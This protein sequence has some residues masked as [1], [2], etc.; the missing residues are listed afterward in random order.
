MDNG[1][2][3]VSA[4]LKKNG[5]NLAN[6]RRDFYEIS[7]ITYIEAYTIE[8]ILSLNANDYIQLYMSAD[9]GTNSLQYTGTGTTPTRPAAPSINFSV[10]QIR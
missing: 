8:Y 5:T 6:T 3:I 1:A 2:Q 7:T 9:G 4:W 10:Q